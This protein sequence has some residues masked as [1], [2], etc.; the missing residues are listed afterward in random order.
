MKWKLTNDHKYHGLVQGYNFLLPPCC[1]E[2]AEVP[3]STGPSIDG[4]ASQRALLGN[5]STDLHG[6]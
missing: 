5:D 1:E 6:C 3:G 2:Y 4:P